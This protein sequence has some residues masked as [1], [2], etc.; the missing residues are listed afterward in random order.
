MDQVTQKE[1]ALPSGYRMPVIGLGTWQLTG[2]QA[3]Q[4]VAQAL[5]V[6]YRHI[7]TAENY[8]NEE[9]IGRA[10]RG[11]DRNALFITSKVDP[12]HAHRKGVIGLANERWTACE[13]ITSTSISCTGLPRTSRRRNHGRHGLA[14]RTKNDPS[15]GLSN[16]NVAGIRKVMSVTDVP[17]CNNQIEY[18][19]CEIAT[20]SWPSAATT[21]SA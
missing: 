9:A 20:T 8:G 18:I 12:S 17:I 2:H 6:G 13:R 16:F 5:D 15:A 4:I 21:R 7:D 3:E 14:H 19:R 11:A 10:I 1:I